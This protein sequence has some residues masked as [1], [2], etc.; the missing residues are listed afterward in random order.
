MTSD[1][2]PALTTTGTA[3]VATGLTVRAAEAADL[4]PAAEVR[5]ASWRA[6]YAGLVPQDF[7]DAMD[8]RETA[9][10][11]SESVAAGRSRLHVAHRA[12]Q[13]VGYAGVGPER[14]PSAP[15]GTGELFALYVHPDAWGTGTGRALLDAAIAD[16]RVHGDE[17]VWLWVLEAN[18]RGRRCYERYGFT[19]TPDRTFSSLG[20]LP[21]IRYALAL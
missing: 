11:W 2:A 1:D 19:Q 13:V 17:R 9:H 18:A 6:A 3:A 20:N 16:C 5:V 4:L 21:E 15:A 7:L 10:R 8:A 12:G 14:D